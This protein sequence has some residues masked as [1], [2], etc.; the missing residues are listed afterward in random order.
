MLYD[1]FASK[2]DLYR[3]LLEHARDEFVEVWRRNLAA[4]EP[5]APRFAR[6]VNAWA[7]YV[8]QHPDTTRIYFHETTGDPEI[9]ALHRTIQAGM[10]I[11]LTGIIG[12]R[13]AAPDEDATGD[14]DLEMAAELIRAAFAGLANWW[15]EHPDVPRERIVAAA[16]DGIWIGL[17]RVGRGES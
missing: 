7:A 9:R 8:E 11:A 13:R 2:A 10:R 3:S 16:V 5:A 4:D 1:H 12:P 6:A 17:E 15:S 14:Q